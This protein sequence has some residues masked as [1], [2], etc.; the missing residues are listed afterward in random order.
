MLNPGE[1]VIRDRDRAG[2]LG[3]DMLELLPSAVR[4]G[5]QTLVLLLERVALPL[6]PLVLVKHR[7]DGSYVMLDRIDPAERI[8]QRREGL[9]WRPFRRDRH[10]R[11]G[12]DPQLFVDFRTD[13]SF[14]SAAFRG[15]RRRPVPALS[16]STI[17]G[18]A[19]ACVSG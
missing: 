4:F 8:A 16:R 13:P 15:G 10:D 5:P 11:V 2:E 1:K 12:V 3:I 6:Q 14:H 17:D 7:A 18:N 9:G 19:D